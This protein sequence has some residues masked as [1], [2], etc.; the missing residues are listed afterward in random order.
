MDPKSGGPCQG[1]RNTIAAMKPL[2]IANE[3][4]CL[5]AP[6]AEY[7]GKDEF[8]IHALGPA[9]NPWQYSK[10]LIPWLL[11]NAKRFDAII[12]HGLW[13]FPSYAV[14]KAVRVLRLKE[15][16][17]VIPW[18]VMPHGMLDPYFQKAK[19]RR[20]KAIRNR[21]YWSLLEE[22]VV[23]SA[24]AVLFTCQE[25]L[26]L[27]RTTF[28]KYQ[29]KAE[30]NV[31]YGIQSPPVFEPDMSTA[32]SLSS[33]LGSNERYFLFLSRIHPKKG[34]DLLLAAYAEI[35]AKE[36]REGRGMPKLV[37]AGPGISTDF[38]KHLAEMVDQNA[39]LKGHVVFPGMLS[40]NSKWGAF[41]HAEAFIL[42][43]HQENFGIA[44][45][46]ALACKTPVLISNQINIWREIEKD[47]GGLV[48]EDSLQ[49]T[50]KLLERWTAMSK[51]EQ[52][53]MRLSAETTY[54]NNFTISSNIEK[55]IGK[56]FGEIAQ[57]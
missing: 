53:Q 51:D 9:N 26:N 13:L 28:K 18:Y 31:G 38:G 22:K 8:E 7:L 56:L 10:E 11:D 15:G 50:I 24:D 48:E 54:F 44:V 52:A 36:E 49:G 14:M 45:A 29:P 23:R 57:H 39:S 47:N 1:I 25:E 35:L 2:N 41:Y 3:V 34:V 30:W 4:V 17:H 20:V 37:I 12:A 55:L 6:T 43:S 33:G 46:E 21:L 32:F 40:G 16:T 19:E 5:D 27:A 42:P